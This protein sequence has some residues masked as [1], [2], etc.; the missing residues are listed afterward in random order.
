MIKKSLDFPLDIN[1]R[2]LYGQFQGEIGLVI[3]NQKVLAEAQFYSKTCRF[4]RIT[5]LYHIVHKKQLFP[6]LL[7]KSKRS[8]TVGNAQNVHLLTVRII[9][10]TCLQ[11]APHYYKKGIF[12]VE[13][14]FFMKISHMHSIFTI[15]KGTDTVR[16][17]LTVRTF[18]AS[19]VSVP[20]CITL[21]LFQRVIQIVN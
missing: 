9:N 21:S 18:L 12:H 4:A 6:T 17:T 2:I 16:G 1:K 5:H 7:V 10:Q 20:D 15:K 13:N 19:T 11:C 8:S 3:S 14:D